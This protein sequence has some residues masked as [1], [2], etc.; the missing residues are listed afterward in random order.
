MGFRN[1]VFFQE[2][3]TWLGERLSLG[4]DMA[5]VMET[6][7]AIEAGVEFR[8]AKLWILVLAVFVASLG[9]NTNSA[10]VIIGAMLIS[11]LMGP[12]IGMGLGVGTN[13]FALFKRAAKNYII[14]TLFSVATATVY[15]LISPFDEV[16]SELLARTSPTIYDVGIALCGGLAGIIALSSRSQRMGNVIPGVAIATALMPPLCTVGFG[17]GTGNW[18][19]ALGALYLYLINTIFISLATFIGVTVVMRFPKKEFVDKNNEK[20]VKR[21]ITFISVVTIIPSIVITFNIFRETVFIDRCQE[22]CRKAVSVKDASLISSDFDYSSKTVRLVFIGQEVD[23]AEI[24]YMESRLP[25][26]GLEGVKLEV[27]QGAKNVDIESVRGLIHTEKDNAVIAQRKLF[28]S[29][30][31]LAA[32]RDSLGR[33]IQSGEQSRL[34]LPELSSLF[35]AVSSVSTGVGLH[36]YWSGT[37]AQD[38]AVY[39][40]NVVLDKEIGSEELEKMEAWLRVRLRRS[41]FL[42]VLKYNNIS[43]VGE[44]AGESGADNVTEPVLADTLSVQ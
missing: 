12:I 44:S 33:Y 25:E 10:A 15:F 18:L 39:I 24:G 2:I 1:D 6:R 30:K 31:K 14:A 36:T 37:M 41:D 40:V 28:E 13:D 3:K 7:A 22:F 38:S 20:R 26:Y 43:S 16:Q 42:M 27:A 5:P 35:P 9:L 17:I 29:E 21:I 34:L 11:P 8:G 19:F 4:S 32:I 23:S